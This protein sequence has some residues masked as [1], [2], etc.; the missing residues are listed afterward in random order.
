MRVFISYA[1]ESDD[2]RRNV[3]ALATRLRDE[4]VDA[5]IDQFVEDDPPYWPTWMIG[6]IEQADYVLCVVTKTYRARF[7]SDTRMPK[8]R[9]SIGKDS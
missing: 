5:W 6:Q 4:G 2:H 8:G 9:G 7:E 3:A 1:H